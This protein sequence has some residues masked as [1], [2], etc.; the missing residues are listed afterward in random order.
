[1]SRVL[2]L[3]LP[4]ILLSTLAHSQEASTWNWNKYY[5]TTKWSV[6]VTED[7]SGCNG[8]STSWETTASIDFNLSSAV[9]GDVGHGPANGAFISGNILEIAPRS[10]LDQPGTS[11]LSAYDV[12]FTSD[13]SAFAASYSWVYTD[14]NPIYDCSGTTT[15]AGTNQQNGCPNPAAPL[16]ENQTPTIDQQLEQANSDLIDYVQLQNASN[17]LQAEISIDQAFLQIYTASGTAKNAAQI[18][19][20]QQQISSLNNQLSIVNGRIGQLEPNVEAEYNS[21]LSED[22]NNFDANLD[23][24]ILKKS[25]GIPHEYFDYMDK[26]MSSGQFTPAFKATVMSNVAKDLGFSTFPS[27]QNSL[28]I[29][30]MQNEEH[31]ETGTIYNT[32]VQSENTAH[33]SWVWKLFGIDSP[34]SDFLNN[35]PS[36]IVNQ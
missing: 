2:L 11:A 19:S 9:M 13:C 16:L 3:L 26:A 10:V 25:E 4:L 17:D 18:S 29:Q 31:S 6:N 33:A 35:I 5:G 24:A 1:M 30:E 34:P 20:L 36:Q 21:V 28:V 14:P 22:P 8:G 7:D 23:M 15:L 12:Y 27:A 32:N